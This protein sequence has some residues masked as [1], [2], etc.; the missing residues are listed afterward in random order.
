MSFRTWKSCKC[1]RAVGSAQNFIAQTL[2]PSMTT[3][4]GIITAVVI[5]NYDPDHGKGKV[6][7]SQG[8]LEL[9]VGIKD[10][11]LNIQ[12]LRCI[13]QPSPTVFTISWVLFAFTSSILHHGYQ[14]VQYRD[15]ILLAVCGGGMA[16]LLM[17][18]NKNTLEIVGLYLPYLIQAAF[19]IAMIVDMWPALSRDEGENHEAVEDVEK[20]GVECERGE[21]R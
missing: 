11:F 1:N 4:V 6:E 20:N 18:Y 19:L 17:L 5:S 3:V 14:D 16:W 2:G 7:V 13:E 8:L 12:V 9:V 21:V 15:H 10:V